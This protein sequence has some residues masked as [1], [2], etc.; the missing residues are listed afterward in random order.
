MR[1]RH[2]AKPTKD[3]N[4]ICKVDSIQS[5]VRNQCGLVQL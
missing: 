5:I 1:G 2:D 3:V 4:T